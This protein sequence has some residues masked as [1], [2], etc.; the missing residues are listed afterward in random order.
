M[1]RSAPNPVA[2]ARFVDLVRSDEGRRVLAG[3][4]F[5]T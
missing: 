2:A 5:E 3:A 4:G 1:V